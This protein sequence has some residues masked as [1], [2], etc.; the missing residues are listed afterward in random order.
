MGMGQRDFHSKVLGRDIAPDFSEFPE[1]W[2]EGLDEDTMLVSQEYDPA[3]NKYGT[4]LSLLPWLPR[5]QTPVPFL[6]C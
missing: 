2:F 6:R 4:S 3:V 5:Y 1:D